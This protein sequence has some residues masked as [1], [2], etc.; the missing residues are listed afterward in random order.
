MGVAGKERGDTKR[1]GGLGS[2]R[3]AFWDCSR[4]QLF[5]AFYL[6]ASR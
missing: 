6:A 4:M 3:A 2:T 5:F 1:V